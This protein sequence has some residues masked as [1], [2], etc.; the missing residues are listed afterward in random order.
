MAAISFDEAVGYVA[1]G[2]ACLFLGAGFS[3]EFRDVEQRPLPLSRELSTEMVKEAGGRDTSD[4]RVAATQLLRA[5]GVD[6]Y[7]A[8]LR[9]R[10]SV[11]ES[12]P[13]AT[14]LASERWIRVYTTNFDDGFER[15][16]ITAGKKYLTATVSD[17]PAQYIASPRVCV[18]IHG[19]VDRLSAATVQQDVVLTLPGYASGT[20]ALSPWKTFSSTTS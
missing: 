2:Q 6:E 9:N 11:R 1:R 16:A 12:Y 14:A 5:R 4:L 8:F 19:F 10:F 13:A 20:F 17:L 18:H 15:A 7:V 3:K